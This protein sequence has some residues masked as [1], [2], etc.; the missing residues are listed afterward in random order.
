MDMLVSM[1]CELYYA[2]DFD[3]EGLS[4]AQRLLERYPESCHLWHM[5][6]ASYEASHPVMDVS[7]RA[8]K[9]VAITHPLLV[10]LADRLKQTGKAGYQ[11]ALL[12]QYVA[13]LNKSF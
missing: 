9:L 5:D 12:E 1:D 2:G 4:M 11:E 8:N 10:P 13:D 6:V 3:P 7:E